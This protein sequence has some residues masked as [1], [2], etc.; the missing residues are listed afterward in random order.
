VAYILNFRISLLR[1]SAQPN[2]TPRSA[3]SP[4]SSFTNAPTCSPI[5]SKSIADNKAN[6]AKTIDDDEPNDWDKHIFSTGCAT[7]NTK[8]NDC[9]FEMKDLRLCKKE[10]EQ[11]KA[12]WK[13]QKNDERTG[14][15]H[16]LGW[17]NRTAYQLHP[18]KL[19]I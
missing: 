5:M 13:N 1:D 9:Y 15:K 2:N 14:M 3:K 6:S 18:F 7:E 17:R 4:K 10:I 19:K 12:C 8:L 11:F 16:A